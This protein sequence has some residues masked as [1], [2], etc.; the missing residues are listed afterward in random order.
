MILSP[1]SAVTLLV[2]FDA[3]FARFIAPVITISSIILSF[4]EI[5]NEDFWYHHTQVALE[6]GCKTS[7]VV[8]VFVG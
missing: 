6:N 5:Q 4:N 3:T 7:V 2:R 8:V 1:F